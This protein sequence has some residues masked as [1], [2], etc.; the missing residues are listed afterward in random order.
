MIRDYKGK[1]PQIAPTVFLAENCAVIGDVVLADRVNI[2]YGAVLRG[3]EGAIEVGENSNIQDNA[4]VHTNQ[5][6]T[7]KIGKNVT[8]GHNAVIHG[9]TV[10]DGTTVGMGAVILNGAVVGSGC[11]IAAGALIKEGAVIPDG[12]LCV[13]V[14]AKIVREMDE[15]SRRRMIENAQI[16]VELGEEYRK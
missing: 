7:V 12:S 14:P 10:G 15:N 5:E 13:G 9:C 4:T 11:M 8:V 6:Y 3:D 1:M 16:Y 2:W